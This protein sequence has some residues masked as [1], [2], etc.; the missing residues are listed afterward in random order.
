MSIDGGG[1][2]E[3]LPQNKPTNNGGNEKTKTIRWPEFDWMYNTWE[4]ISNFAYLKGVATHHSKMRDA[5][6]N[7]T[8]TNR[9]ASLRLKRAEI[10]EQ[11]YATKKNTKERD[12]LLGKANRYE[13]LYR[14]LMEE[15]KMVGVTIEGCGEQIGSCV[16]LFCADPNRPI[17]E[18]VFLWPS[19]SSGPDGNGVLPIEIAEQLNCRVIVQ[20]FPN[21]LEGKIT[22][23]FAEA[24]KIQGLGPFVEF[25]IGATLQV[26]NS[27]GINK[28]KLVGNSAGSALAGEALKSEVFADRISSATL[29]AAGGCSD[30]VT[31]R[32]ILIEEAL[33]LKNDIVNMPKL[34]PINPENLVIDKIGRESGLKAHYALLKLMLS[35]IGWWKGLEHVKTDI[36]A[37]VYKE[38]PVGSIER[39]DDLKKAG[40]EVVVLDGSHITPMMHPEETIKYI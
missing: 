24:V 31:F 37:V 19:I 26:A 13:E 7:Q 38:D 34:S 35:N 15:R 9:P 32:K 16:E 18:T 22:P 23:A 28:F 8:D 39:A 27:L 2:R 14:Q 4:R 3:N 30:K 21:A 25:Y 10:Y 11:I 40:V 29:I 17:G 5:L 36:K 1:D 6:G 33:F 12:L 20:G